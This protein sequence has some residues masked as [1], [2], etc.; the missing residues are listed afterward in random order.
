MDT[1]DTTDKMPILEHVDYNSQLTYTTQPIQPSYSV[2]DQ[3]IQPSYS[4]ASQSVQPSYSVASQ[5]VQSSYSIASQPVQPSYSIA[6]QTPQEMQL[7]HYNRLC[8]RNKDIM[9]LKENITEKQA[10]VRQLYIRMQ[11][12]N[13]ELAN[14]EHTLSGL[15]ETQ[16]VDIKLYNSSYPDGYPVEDVKN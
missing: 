15:I 12:L 14:T 2:T 3:P 1:I 10:A 16:V 4:V 6:T 11:E 7:R 5:P 9:M 13:A 8:T